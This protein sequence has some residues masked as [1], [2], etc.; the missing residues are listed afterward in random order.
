MARDNLAM[1]IA[2]HF[3]GKTVLPFGEWQSRYGDCLAILKVQ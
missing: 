3:E 1:E 2:C